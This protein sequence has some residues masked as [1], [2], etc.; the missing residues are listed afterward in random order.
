MALLAAS[1]IAGCHVVWPQTAN[2]NGKDTDTATV[3]DASTRRDVAADGDAAPR[4]DASTV[5]DA[6]P[7]EAAIRDVAPSPPDIG[8]LTFSQPVEIQG[9]NSERSDKAPHLSRDGNRLYF[10]SDR[11]GGS[12][13]RDIWVADYI[14]GTDFEFATPEPIPGSVNSE[15]DDED[16]TLTEDEMTLYYEFNGPEGSVV[17][18]VATRSPLTGGFEPPVP[19]PGFEPN[20]PNERPGDPWIS[21]DGKVLYFAALRQGGLGGPDIWSATVSGTG[22]GSVVHL[23][24][25]NSRFHEY[26][27]ALDSAQRLLLVSTNWPGGKG[28]LDLYRADRQG[29]AFGPAV[30]LEAVNTKAGEEDP[31]ISLELGLLIFSTDRGK[32]YD[33]YYSTF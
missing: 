28:G 13:R 16:P 2:P 21:P 12:G 32:S 14:P 33:L 15:W 30:P 20:E 10:A 11:E 1:G 27:P 25:V 31:F 8:T 3:G 26:D 9:V 17:L 19:V 5:A 6:A 18:K 24:G 4:R 7:P 29:T 23:Q 22:F